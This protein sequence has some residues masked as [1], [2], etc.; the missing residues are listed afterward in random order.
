[1]WHLNMPPKKSARRGGASPAHKPEA[2]GQSMDIRMG[3]KLGKDELISRLTVRCGGGGPGAR[4]DPAPRLTHV[5]SPLQRLTNRLSEMGQRE[6]LEGEERAELS[7]IEPFIKSLPSL[8]GSREK[9]GPCL[10]LCAAL[11]PRE[12]TGCCHSAVSRR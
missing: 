7:R 2:E 11:R 5:A 3:S 6:D 1:V 8:M 9:V 12:L 10:E 4:G